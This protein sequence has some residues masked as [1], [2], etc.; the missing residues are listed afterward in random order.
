[1]KELKKVLLLAIILIA[2]SISKAYATT[3]TVNTDG[4][5]VRKG[6]STDDEIIQTLNKSAEVEIIGESGDW[7]KIKYD[8]DTTFEGYMHRYKE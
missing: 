5:R 4:V 7:Y 1:M 6:P 8:V 2:V 3:G